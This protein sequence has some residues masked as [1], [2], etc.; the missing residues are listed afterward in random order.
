MDDEVLKADEA[1]AFLIITR[2][3]V[4]DLAAQGEIPSYHLFGRRHLRFRKTDL[5]ALLKPNC[6]QV[7]NEVEVNNA[8]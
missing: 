6:Q 3:A 4:Y 5:Q 7:G 1:A 8:N 2:R